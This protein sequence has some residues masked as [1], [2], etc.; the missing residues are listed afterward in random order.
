MGI[1]EGSLFQDGPEE[2][3]RVLKVIEREGGS[4]HMTRLGGGVLIFLWPKAISEM[5][6]VLVM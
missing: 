4:S 2:D 5:G 1:W 6:G 3:G